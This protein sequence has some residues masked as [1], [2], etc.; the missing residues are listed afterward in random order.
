METLHEKLIDIQQRLKVAKDQVNEFGNFNYRNLEDIE[1][2]VKPL[3]KE[4]KLTLIFEDEIIAVGERVYVKATASLYDGK[5][6]I[7]NSAYAREAI[8]PKAK[9]D[10]AQLTGAC[11]SYARKYAAGGLF[12]I[13]NTKDADSM[14]NSKRSKASTP[15]GTKP[16]YATMKQI[17]LMVNKAKWGLN[18]FDKDEIINWL[19]NVIGKD[20]SKVEMA[21]VDDTLAKID[22]A[23]REEKV[24]KKAN[25][26]FPKKDV[27][28]SLTDKQLQEGISLDD[29]P[30]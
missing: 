20:L 13:D 27:V 5:T 15:S 12:L 14:D 9:T 19:D 6:S 1:T 30:Y 4:H 3:L 17:E 7:R 25:T 10:D 2:A 21:E 18:I 29:I 23:L 26:S 24:N 11:S 16:R 22:E 8:T 28:V